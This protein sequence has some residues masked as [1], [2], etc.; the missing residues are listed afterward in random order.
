MVNRPCYKCSDRVVGCHSI[1][2]EYQDFLEKN[3]NEKK[4]INEEKLESKSR[5]TRKTWG[6]IRSRNGQR[7]A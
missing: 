7:K 2:D 6:F 1:C 5:Y 3:R 4:R